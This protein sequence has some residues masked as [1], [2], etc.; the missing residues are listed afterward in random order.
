MGGLIGNDILRRFNIIIN[1]AKGDIFITPN[2]H[3]TDQFDYSYSGVELYMIEGL[4][5][6][7]DVAKGSPGEAAGLKEGD[8]VLAINKN[9]SQNLNQ[10]KIALQAPNEKIKIIFRR[11]GKMM[12]VEF[13]IKSIL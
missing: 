12:E 9:F 7:G 4:I 8:Q 10:Y 3:F 1:Y 13:K 11:D 6:V 5:I 2:R